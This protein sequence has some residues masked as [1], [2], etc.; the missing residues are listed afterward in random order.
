[1]SGLAVIGRIF[2]RGLGQVGGGGAGGC[3]GGGHVCLFLA[4]G[5]NVF[6]KGDAFTCPH[7]GQTN[8]SKAS[9]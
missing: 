1:M 6:R 8:F 5:E 7:S 4:V 2:L 9:I 3:I